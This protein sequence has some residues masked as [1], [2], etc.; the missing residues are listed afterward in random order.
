MCI[1]LQFEFV[2]AHYEWLATFAYIQ[3]QFQY[4]SHNLSLP[5]SS[6]L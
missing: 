4:I 3:Q 5:L 2:C 6:F 1:V